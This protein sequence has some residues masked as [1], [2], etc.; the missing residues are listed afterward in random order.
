ML[1]QEP[2]ALLSRVPRAV[3]A[4]HCLSSAHVKSTT[5]TVGHRSKLRSLRWCPRI[6][7]EVNRKPVR[8]RLKASRRDQDC[9]AKK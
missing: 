8:P 9:R 3:A 4:L 7:A 5:A 6:L 2:S 1:C